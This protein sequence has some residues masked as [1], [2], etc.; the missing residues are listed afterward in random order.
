MTAQTD[1]V[2]YR[3]SLQTEGT[4]LNVKLGDLARVATLF[5][6]GTMDLLQLMNSLDEIKAADVVTEA[7]ADLKSVLQTW[8]TVFNNANNAI[9]TNQQIM[10]L[11]SEF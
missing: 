6:N 2:E 9:Q 3:N 10:D 5:R 8:Y 4:E 7:P 1:Y 11:L